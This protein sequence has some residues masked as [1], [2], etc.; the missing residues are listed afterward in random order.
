[1]SKNI[2]HLAPDETK[3]TR[4]LKQLVEKIE[5]VELQEDKY[6]HVHGKQLYATLAVKTKNHSETDYAVI[7]RFLE[8]R[9]IRILS[10]SYGAQTVQGVP[11]W[12]KGQMHIDVD[13]SKPATLQSAVT[14]LHQAK[15]Y[16][17]HS[18]QDISFAN[19]ILC[20][21]SAKKLR[22]CADKI[23]HYT[24]DEKADGQKWMKVY[25]NNHY[26]PQDQITIQRFLEDDNITTKQ[27]AKVT[28][29]GST[30]LPTT[31]CVYFTDITEETQK[32]DEAMK[33]LL[34]QKSQ[35]IVS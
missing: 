14:E 10:A 31:T 15:H 35:R 24:I 32:V 25:F 12:G 19:R 8:D 22:K 1:M 30:D 3:H 7:K 21:Q 33:T 5:S 2:D 16:D 6:P 18:P 9:D 20:E 23:T 26:D 4:E 27:G 11:V 34:R 13:A 17:S 28:N 29:F